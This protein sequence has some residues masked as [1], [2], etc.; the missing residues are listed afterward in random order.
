MNKTT[1]YPLL[2]HSTV[3]VIFNFIDNHFKEIIYKGDRLSF[4]GKLPLIMILRA[5]LETY[6]EDILTCEKFKSK[7]GNIACR[8]GFPET[9]KFC[10]PRHMI[11][12]FD[13]CI[14]AFHGNLTCI[15]AIV[16]TPVNGRNEDWW[17]GQTSSGL[18][19]YGNHLNCLKLL[20]SYGNPKSTNVSA[21]ACLHGSIDCFMF[22][23]ENGYPMDSDTLLNA[24]EK[25]HLEC[26]HFALKIRCE[27]TKDLC[28]IAAKNGDVDILTLLRKYHYP[29][30]GTDFFGI[31]ENNRLNCLKYMLYKEESFYDFNTFVS[32]FDQ[33]FIIQLAIG[34]RHY[35]CLELLLAYGCTPFDGDEGACTKAASIGELNMLKTLRNYDI[36]W[37]DSVIAAAAQNGHYHCLD[38][39]INNSCPFDDN[40]DCYC[41]LAAQSGNLNCLLLIRARRIGIFN[42]KT[43]LEGAM[44]GST[45]RQNIIDW[46]NGNYV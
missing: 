2:S 26:V 41:Y 15:D 40:E 18:A 21:L 10:L 43:V 25:G 6:F 7:I 31:V 16:K 45:V 4:N 36:D 20:H 34:H 8:K 24:V 30:I 33:N 9:V 29:F 1:S 17:K 3:D 22:A 32:H 5:G 13:L 38:Y 35:E 11:S 19:A 39:A 37:T 23:Y 28:A 42:K 44:S 27:G 46:I 12:R 14:A